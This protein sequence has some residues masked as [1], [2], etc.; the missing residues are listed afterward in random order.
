MSS[1]LHVPRDRTSLQSE[2]A[3]SRAWLNVKINLPGVKDEEL[4]AK[5]AKAEDMLKEAEEIAAKIY[6]DVEASL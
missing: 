4:Q 5:F 6:G 1:P 3:S 2:K